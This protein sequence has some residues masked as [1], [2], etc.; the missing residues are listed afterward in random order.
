MDMHHVKNVCMFP[1]LDVCHALHAHVCDMCETFL[2]KTAKSSLSMSHMSKMTCIAC[3]HMEKMTC[4]S[5]DVHAVHAMHAHA[6]V[7]GR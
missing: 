2:I 3:T 5:C 4:I 6:P 7:N 1:T